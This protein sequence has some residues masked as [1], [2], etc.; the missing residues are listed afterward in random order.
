MTLEGSAASLAHDPRIK[1]AY[2]GLLDGDDATGL[3]SASLTR[4]DG[5]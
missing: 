2:L 3:T 4:R 5:M 1:E